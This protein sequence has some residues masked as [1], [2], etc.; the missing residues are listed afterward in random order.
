MRHLSRKDI[1]LNQAINHEDVSAGAAAPFQWANG[2]KTD[3]SD[4]LDQ[5]DWPVGQGCSDPVRRSVAL[6]TVSAAR[7][8]V[9]KK[10]A[11]A[12]FVWGIARLDPL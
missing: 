12:Q 10:W 9:A 1:D 11:A 2:L 7:W 4:S 3:N 5:R 8:L 6:A